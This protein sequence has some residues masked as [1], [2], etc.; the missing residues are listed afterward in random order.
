MGKNSPNINNIM[1]KIKQYEKLGRDVSMVVKNLKKGREGTAI[2]T[3]QGKIAVF[4]GKDD[5]SDDKIYS[6]EEFNRNYEV[7]RLEDEYENEL[8]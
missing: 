6:L 4:E 8:V 5:G 7:I 1:K 2:L 3:A